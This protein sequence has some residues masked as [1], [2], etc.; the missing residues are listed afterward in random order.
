LRGIRL[1]RT[2]RK[3][4][5][6]WCKKAFLQASEKTLDHFLFKREIK[7]NDNLNINGKQQAKKDWI[8]KEFPKVPG[9]DT[10]IPFPSFK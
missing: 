5:I 2:A 9:D 3:N 6:E 1:R 10:Y 4:G 7:T 8:D